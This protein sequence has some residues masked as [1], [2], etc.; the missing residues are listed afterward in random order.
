MQ[1]NR[2]RLFFCKK[3]TGTITDNGPHAM[4]AWYLHARAKFLCQLAIFYNY[5]HQTKLAWTWQVSVTVV[6]LPHIFVR[7]NPMDNALPGPIWY[8]LAIV[9][10]KK[11]SQM[12]Q[13]DSKSWADTLGHQWSLACH[14]E[15]GIH[16]PTVKVRNTW[17]KTRG[18]ERYGR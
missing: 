5:K 6:Q 13:S 16:T 18:M 4:L 8:V 14:V 9:F 3:M 2:I 1:N 7:K 10:M 15:T 17:Q 12:D 11:E